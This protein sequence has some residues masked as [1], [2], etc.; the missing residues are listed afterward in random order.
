MPRAL[1]IL[2]I[3][4]I[5]LVSLPA[6]T[7][8]ARLYASSPPASVCQGNSFTMRLLLDSP[9]E[10]INAGQVDLSFDSSVMQVTS[11]NWSSSLFRF[12]AEGPTW[13]NGTG[14]IHMVGGLPTPGFQGTGGLVAELTISADGT[15]NP[16]L[17]YE[18]ST[19]ILLDDGFGTSTTVTFTQP[20]FTVLPSIDPACVT[21]P[22]TPGPT[23]PP[24][25]PGPTPPPSTP[26]PTPTPCPT[27][28]LYTQDGEVLDLRL[29]SVRVEC[30][31]SQ[32]REFDIF[33]GADDPTHCPIVTRCAEDAGLVGDPQTVT[34]NVFR[35][36]FLTIGA[37]TQGIYLGPFIIG[38]GLGAFMLLAAYL[39]YKS[40][41]RWY[42]RVFKGRQRPPQYPEPP[43]RK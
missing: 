17:R 23:P 12:F 35:S 14:T 7:L 8:A 21:P 22:S 33:L 15:G 37:V 24:G 19:D 4:V 9:S 31:S 13:N 18:D 38:I 3:S 28:E 29:C 27:C 11:M 43:V 41:R 34:K 30:T 6:S 39:L 16:S 42:V 26:G 32:S 10:A 2:I 36:P 1:T 5:G 20:S 25:T 40:V